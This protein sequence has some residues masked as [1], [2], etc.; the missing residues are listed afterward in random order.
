MPMTDVDERQID[1]QIREDRR[2]ARLVHSAQERLEKALTRL[3]L[4]NAGG[5]VVT[6]SYLGASHGSNHAALYPLA[7]FLFGLIF[8][9]V[10]EIVVLW[11][12]QQE[13]ARDQNARSWLERKAGYAKSPVQRSGIVIDRET[14]PVALAL[15]CFIAGC[16]F[17]WWVAMM[18]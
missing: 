7:C 10:S 17:G 3:W 14:V 18:A 8:L 9:G 4:G 11:P 12:M 16:V 15:L 5:A 13:I 1:E 2:I 6:V